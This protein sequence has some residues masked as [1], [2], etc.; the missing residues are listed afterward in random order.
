MLNSTSIALV[1]HHSNN[2]QGHHTPPE[3]VID[4]LP[5]YDIGYDEP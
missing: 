5:Y 3:V 2:V 1:I 4:I